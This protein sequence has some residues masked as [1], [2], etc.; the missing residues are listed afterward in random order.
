MTLTQTDK[1]NREHKQT[2]INDVR[3]AIDDYASLYLFSYENMR[4][5][6]FKNVRMDFKDSRIFLGKNK[7][8]QIAMGKTPEDEY[9]E[10]LR[11]VSKLCSGSVGLLLTDE[12][13]EKVTEYFSNLDEKDFA[14]SGSIATQTIKLTQKDVEVHPVSMVDQFRKLSVP[15]QV[16]KGKV[17][18]VG[19]EF[20]VCKTGEELSADTCKVLVHFGVRMA[21]F[22][23]KLECKYVRES[24]EFTEL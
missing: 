12:K 7:L 6:K 5:S 17:N 18:L 11:Q 10:N 20:I 21:S 2:V 22:T 19:E 8:L 14:R 9:M 23:V 24:E 16:L 1:K 4:S 13:E 15:V 3:G